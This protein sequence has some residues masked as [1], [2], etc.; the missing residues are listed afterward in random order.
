MDG[1]D[2]SA[3]GAVPRRGEWKCSKG[4]EGEINVTQKHRLAFA[5]FKRRRYGVVTQHLFFFYYLMLFYCVFLC[6][7]ESLA[8][9]N[10]SLLDLHVLRVIFLIK[11]TRDEVRT[12]YCILFHFI[13]H[14]LCH[15]IPKIPEEIIHLF[16]A[17]GFA[18]VF[19][20]KRIFINLYNWFFF[21]DTFFDCNNNEHVIM[22]SW[23]IINVVRITYESCIHIV[24]L[25]WTLCYKQ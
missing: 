20:T 1:N 21:S 6:N 18:D 13:L 19:P 11:C 22:C 4:R 16:A 7:P 23:C 12:V 8:V 24:E 15:W 10:P 2:G 14:N 25:L 9:L 5:R 3:E 17:S